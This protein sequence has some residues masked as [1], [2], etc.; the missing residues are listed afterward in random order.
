MVS[1]GD[2]RYRQVLHDF[3]RRA[4]ISP[5]VQDYPLENSDIARCAG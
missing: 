5:G 1:A 2:R 3:S 4:A